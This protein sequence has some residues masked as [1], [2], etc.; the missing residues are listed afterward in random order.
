MTSG[1]GG[2]FPPGLPVGYIAEIGPE[3][4]RVVLHASAYKQKF[5]RLTD[6]GL[7]TIFQDLETAKGLK[8]DATKRNRGKP[9]DIAMIFGFWA[10]TQVFF[11]GLLPVM[12][13]LVLIL[14][15]LSEFFLS[16]GLV[17]KF[18]QCSP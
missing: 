11:L 15:N 8:K 9:A 14:V 2:K 12:F 5:V 1:Y 7:G 13:C 4:V 10:E 3:F 6:V 18:D 17:A 16:S